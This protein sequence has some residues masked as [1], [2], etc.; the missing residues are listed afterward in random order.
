MIK[1]I[2]LG[3]EAIIHGA[4]ESGVSFVSGYPGCPSAEIGDEFA[5]IAKEKGIYV[6][7]STNEKVALEAAIGA[8]F[9]GLKSLVNMKSFGI[10]VCSDSLLPLAYTGTKAGMVIIVA[11]DPSGWSSAQSEQD[12]RGYAYLSHVPMLEPSDP[13][14]AKDFTKLGYEISEKF[15][16]P[17]ILRITTRVAHQRAPVDIEDGKSS[18]KQIGEFISN[19]HQFVTMPPRVLEMKKELLE[20]IE[21]IKEFADK[22]DVNKIN[23]G[24][25]LKDIGIIVSGVSYFHLLEAQKELGLDLS[26]LKL[27]FFYPLP[28]NKIK[29]FIK[30]LKKALIIEE[31]NGYIE[32]EVKVIAKDENLNLEVFGKNMLSE[33]GELNAEMI[34]TVLSKITGKKIKMEKI[35]QVDLPRRTARLCEG[36]PYWHVFPTLKRIAPKGTVFG[37]DIGCYMI[38]GLPPH[39]MQDYLFSMGAGTGISHGVKKSTKQK[40]ISLIGDATFFHA[41]IPEIINTVYNKSNPLII[42]L[43]NRITAMTGHQA[44]PGMGK[45]AMGEDSE[46]LKIE[47]IVKACGV[48]NVKVIDQGN[49]GELENA[50][51]E[52]LDKDEVSVIVCRRICA[53]LAKRQSV[54]THEQ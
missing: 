47:D 36:C 21:K 5:K 50:V 10:N 37:G 38:A 27:G 35:N 12:S 42:V 31:L 22:S 40:V 33:I 14:E 45:N 39:N 16:I 29:N 23:K 2:L 34:L 26:V 32:K 48:K 24:K 11:D 54:D 8:S 18:A 4:L 30:P 46:M 9:S 13:Q 20:K 1:K 25:D 49:P 53:L 3:D 51:K 28:E 43:D 44:N 19:P 52:F 7:W 41:G 6:E 17:V 15:N